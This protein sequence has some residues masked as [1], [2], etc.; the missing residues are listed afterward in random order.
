MRFRYAITEAIKY[1]KNE[2]V[3]S[4]E[5]VDNLRKDILNSPKHILGDHTTCSKYF[6]R[7]EIVDTTTVADMK[8]TRK[9]FNTFH[10]MFDIVFWAL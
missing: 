6:C 8:L 9:L 1:R 2:T 7:K 3:P 10:N 4:A 5:K